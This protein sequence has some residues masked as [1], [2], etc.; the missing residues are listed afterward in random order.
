MKRRD[1]GRDE[2]SNVEMTTNSMLVGVDQERLS[3]ATVDH[4]AAVVILGLP[5]RCW[6]CNEVSTPIVTMTEPGGNEELL[7]LAWQ[8]LPADHPRTRGSARTANVIRERTAR[9]NC[10]SARRSRS[11]SA[12]T[13]AGL[14]A[15]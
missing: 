12:F 2:A 3:E 7:R 8:C 5:Y 13:P 9:P 4:L 6:R 10:R 14:R 15:P 11:R 1:N